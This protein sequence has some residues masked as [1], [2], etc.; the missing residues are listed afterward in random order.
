L[1]GVSLSLRND[2]QAIPPGTAG[3]SRSATREAGNRAT[4]IPVVG[5]LT[6]GGIGGFAGVL[7]AGDVGG[8]A[9]TGGETVGRVGNGGVGTLS[10]DACG[11]SGL[12]IVVSGLGG[13]VGGIA[14]DTQANAPTHII[15]NFPN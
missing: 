7:T 1:G 5:I 12:S 9:G 13:R 14:Q 6:A 2:S 10:A 4:A 3:I 8:F 15:K 11:I